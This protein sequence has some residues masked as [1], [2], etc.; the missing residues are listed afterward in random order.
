LHKVGRGSAQYFLLSGVVVW[1]GLVALLGC[2]GRQGQQ[3]NNNGIEGKLI[4]ARGTISTRGSTP[5]SMVMLEASDGRIYV[6]QSSLLGDELRNLVA[7]D[8]SVTGKILH[9]PSFDEPL[10]DVVSYDLMSL[11]SGEVPIVG[12]VRPGG[13]IEDDNMMIWMIEGDFAQILH[14]FVGSKVWIVGVNQRWVNTASGS[15]RAIAVT[16]YGLIRK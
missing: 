12:I 15:H 3:G 5:F 1:C 11:P 7:M 9:N 10:L 16:E 2:A 4:V 6:I 13:W 8:V 14:T